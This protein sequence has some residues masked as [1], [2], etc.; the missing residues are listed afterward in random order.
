MERQSFQL[1]G[2]CAMSVPRSLPPTNPTAPSPALQHV[3]L[4]GTW[5]RHDF[6]L[7][8]RNKFISFIGINIISHKLFQGI[9]FQVP[10]NQKTHTHFSKFQVLHCI[11]PSLLNELWMNEWQFVDDKLWA[12]LL[13]YEWM[14][15]EWS[16]DSLADNL[17]STN[18]QRPLDRFPVTRPNWA[19]KVNCHSSCI[20]S[21]WQSMCQRAC[22]C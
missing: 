19:K 2:N 1:S 22:L 17:S 7:K 6:S 12:K 21:L 14:K 15:E 13:C 10:K 18:C 8:T 4:V 20:L 16:L 9:F 5:L 11:S 3:L